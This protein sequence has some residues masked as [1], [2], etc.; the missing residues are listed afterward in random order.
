MFPLSFPSSDNSLEI[1]TELL[2]FRL[3]FLGL[4]FGSSPPS[5]VLMETPCGFPVWVSVFST[6]PAWVTATARHVIIVDHE[7]GH[8]RYKV[9]RVYNVQD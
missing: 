1:C 4:L 7:V 9:V 2:E 5:E 6:K 3:E 8:F